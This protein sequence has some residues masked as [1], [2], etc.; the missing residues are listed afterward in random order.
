[1]PYAKLRSDILAARDLRQD[2]LVQL[3][4]ADSRTLILMSLNIP[5]RDKITIRFRPLFDWGEQQLRSRIEDLE[6]IIRLTDVLGPWALYASSL[7]AAA[8]KH[9][10]CMIEESCAAARLLDIDIYDSNAAA[11]HRQQLGHA[12]R[13]CFVC[14][15]PATECIRLGRHSPKELQ[16]YLDRLLDHLPT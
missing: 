10:G 6:P 15:A 1:M 3:A 9:I 16:R 7:T 4:A 14:P 12:P 5:G 11:Y 13:P 2:S 8:A